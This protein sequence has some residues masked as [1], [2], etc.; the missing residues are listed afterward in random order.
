M[1]VAAWVSVYSAH[2][3]FPVG[4]AKQATFLPNN[5]LEKKSFPV[6]ITMPL[7]SKPATMGN[8]FGEA[9]KPLK[10]AQSEGLIGALSIF[11][12]TSP[13]AGLGTSNSSMAR[14]SSNFFRTKPFIEF[15]KCVVNMFFI[16][17]QE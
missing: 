3:P 15:G 11:T 1:A 7:P 13:L 8:F 16:R 10:K 9:Y 12:N 17:L 4:G 6:A 2:V 5:L 14:P